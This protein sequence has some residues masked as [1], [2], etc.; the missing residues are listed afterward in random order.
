M[1]LSDISIKRPV[2]ASVISLLLIAFGLVAF[3]RIPLRE[4]PDIDS[5]IVTVRTEYVGA[6]SAVVENRVTRPLE[7]R[8]AGIEGI[9]SITSSSFDGLSTITIEFE[10]SR[11]IDA[12]ANDV[13]DRVAQARRELPDDIDPPEVEKTDADNV[14]ILWLNLSGEGM[15]ILEISDFADRFLVDRFSTVNGVARV[16]VGGS[17]EYSMRIWLDRQ[18]LAARGLTVL[19]VEEALRAQNVELPAGSLKSRQRDFVVRVTRGYATAEDF[20]RLVLRR[21]DDGYLVRLRDVARVEIGPAEWRRLYRGNG[22]NQVGLGVIKQSNA[23]TLE[24]ARAV[25]ALADEINATL[26]PGMKLNQSFDTSVFVSAAIAEVY[27]TL[28]IAGILVILVILAFLGDFR[29]MLIPAAT[30]PVSLIA[31]AIVLYAFGYSLNLLT[32]L[33]LVLAIGLVVDDSIVVLENVHRRLNA[34]ET[35]LVAAFRGTRQVGFAVLA[36]TA[37]LISV[38]VPITFL[39]GTVGRL[40]AEFAVAMAAAV[41]FSALVAL[42]LSP[43]LCSKLLDPAAR[44]SRLGSFIEARLTAMQRL[45]GRALR[46]TL[47]RPALIIA[48]LAGTI[49]ASGLLFTRIPSEFTPREDRGNMFIAVTAPE[50]SSFEYTQ[51]QLLEIEQRLMPLVEAG[52]IM[53]L[54]VQAPIG[55]GAGELYNQG[56]LI[57]VMEDWASRRSIFAM[58]DEVRRR[59][60]DLTG[61]QVFAI[62]I[63]PLSSGNRKPVQFVIGGGTFE[64]LAEWRDILLEAARSN[65]G[66]ID[67][68]ADYKETKPQIHVAIDHNRAGDLGVSTVAISRTLE[69]LLGSR[70]VTTF[71]YQ[72]EEYDVILEGETDLHRTTT[73]LANIYI[74]S[75]TSGE[76]IPLSNLVTLTEQ[77]DAASLNRYNRVRAI[78]IEAS[79]ASGY[80]LGEALDY[81]ERLVQEQLPPTATIDYKGESLEL[82]RSGQ[83][84][85]FL[86][87]LSLV[88]VFLVLAAQFESYIH[89]LVIMLTVPLAVAGALLGLWITGHSLNIYSQVAIIMLVGLAAKNGILLVE[90]ANQLRDE[91][92]A[93]RDAVLRAS[94]LRLRPIVM[95]AFTT[96]MGAVPL[97][98]ASGAGSESRTVIG[99]VVIAGVLMATLLTLFVVPAAYL[100]IAR[101]TSSPETVARQLQTEL[102]TT[103]SADRPATDRGAGPA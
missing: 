59:T 72:G 55:R 65:P 79:L 4:Y 42:T 87:A 85:Y 16:N 26:P 88:V 86:F 81:L 48:V 95:T 24:V 93:F 5:P 82:K 22:I 50:G 29:A 43:M 56:R 8:L 52:E 101:G 6:N 21:G 34:G 77:A 66:L 53:R 35:P 41:F 100:A 25:H 70:R 103:P 54:L 63:Q 89:P 9:R 58:A 83:S 49:V 67:L 37:V 13:R 61:V 30:V 62:P 18:A 78:T 38:F 71:M 39:E 10:L 33:A 20:D 44:H 40:F 19:D 3:E 90:F 45:Y 47:Q 51:R 97:V 99:V 1:L 68:D 31:T 36:T 84:I 57:I 102:D 75:E 73:D 14:P 7:E 27:E 15:S 96:I 28:L 17:L 74:R 2:F 92:L 46:G 98:L 64:E 11:D 60:A 91:G 76:L 12:A 23:N 94:E 80:A 69:T 32:L